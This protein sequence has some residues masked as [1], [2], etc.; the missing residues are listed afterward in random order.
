[1]ATW[2]WILK[3]IHNYKSNWTK[4]FFSEYGWTSTFSALVRSVSLAFVP[5]RQLHTHIAISSNDLANLIFIFFFCYFNLFKLRLFVQIIC[6]QLYMPK[7]WPLPRAPLDRMTTAFGF[8]L[9][10][11]LE[12]GVCRKC[13]EN[14]R[15]IFIVV[16]E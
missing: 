12:C 14:E 5:K 3:M 15:A 7:C 13:S 10:Y 11:T 9:R 4:R 8:Q 6:P 16:C 1:M 2:S